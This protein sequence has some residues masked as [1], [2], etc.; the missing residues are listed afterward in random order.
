MASIQVTIVY[1]TLTGDQ[2]M[3]NIAPVLFSLMLIVLG[4]YLAK[5]RSNWAAGICTPWTMESEHAWSV[6]NRTGGW[7]FVATGLAGLL[8]VFVADIR[9]T[10][11][12]VCGGAVASTLVSFVVSYFAW[13]DDP[14]RAR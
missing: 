14:E 10:I 3:F 9:T 2:T 13:R 4:N 8:A 6:A 5:T 11:F 12:V 7:C 1:R